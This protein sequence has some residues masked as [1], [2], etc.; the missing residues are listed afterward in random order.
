MYR[1]VNTFEWCVLHIFSSGIIFKECLWILAYLSFSLL[2]L[3]K[4]DWNH[5]PERDSILWK[6][7]ICSAVSHA[8]PR[9]H[10]HTHPHTQTPPTPNHSRMAFTSAP[11]RALPLL[12]RNYVAAFKATLCPT[13]LQHCDLS[14]IMKTVD[15]ATEPGGSQWPNAELARYIL[16]GFLLP[17]WD[18]TSAPVAES[19]CLLRQ[20][21][22]LYVQ[23]TIRLYSLTLAVHK[24]WCRSNE[25]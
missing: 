4:L 20:S 16:I 11:C 24:N 9:V 15:L 10:P 12:E 22:G 21:D 13:D 6:A 8:P 7:C 14:F 25:W 19:F 17:T 3:C 23:D 18:Y 1:A 2:L 5:L